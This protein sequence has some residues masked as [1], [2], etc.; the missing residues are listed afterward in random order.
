MKRPSAGVARPPLEVVACFNQDAVFRV[1][2]HTLLLRPAVMFGLF[3]LFHQ[4]AAAYCCVQV[5][6]DR[7]APSAPQYCVVKGQTTGG[8][9]GCRLGTDSSQFTAG[10]LYTTA[11]LFDTGT[12]CRDG[13]CV[14]LRPPECCDAHSEVG[15]A[16]SGTGDGRGALPYATSVPLTMFE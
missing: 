2:R 5:H 10:L 7:K 11:H 14:L 12:Y 16:L 3:G 9:D 6:P 8:A 15:R 13:K 4:S 1:P